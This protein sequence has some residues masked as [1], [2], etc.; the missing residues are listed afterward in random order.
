MQ[1][2]ALPGSP[3]AS[4]ACGTLLCHHGNQLLGS[5]RR[6]STSHLGEGEAGSLPRR[7]PINPQLRPAWPEGALPKACLATGLNSLLSPGRGPPP[8]TPPCFHLW[9][10]PLRLPLKKSR[11]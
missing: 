5:L 4:L 9:H 3:P 1:T 7:L 11:Q 10:Q 8:Y 2:L 6:D